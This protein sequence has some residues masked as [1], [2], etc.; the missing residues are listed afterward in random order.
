MRCPSK[1]T[2]LSVHTYRTDNEWS[3]D[4]DVVGRLLAKQLGPTYFIVPFAYVPKIVTPR[5]DGA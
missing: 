2:Q 3:A 1:N 4:L 5:I